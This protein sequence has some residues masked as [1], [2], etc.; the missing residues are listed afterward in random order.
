[1][2]KLVIPTLA[3]L[4]FNGCSANTSQMEKCADKMFIITNELMTQRLPDEAQPEIA[5]KEFLSN[6]YDVKREYD[7]YS[8]LIKICENEYE[9]DSSKF[10]LE[11]K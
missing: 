7:Y 8:A 5:I 2:T 9:R 3:V 4:L 11:Y 6:S 1:M 10:N